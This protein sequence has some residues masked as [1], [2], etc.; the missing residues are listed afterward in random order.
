MGLSVTAKG[1][2][3]AEVSAHLAEVYGATVSK[4]KIS[5]DHRAVIEE[6]TDWRPVLDAVYP[7]VRPGQVANRAFY[8]TIGV[9]VDGERDILG[10]WSY[11]RARVP[12]SGSGCSPRSRTAASLMC[13]SSSATASKGRPDSIPTTWPKAIVHTC[14]LHLLRNTFRLASRAVHS[15]S[16][17]TSAALLHRRAPDSMLLAANLAASWS[18]YTG[19]RTS[20][21]PSA[22]TITCQPFSVR[23]TETSKSATRFSCSTSPSFIG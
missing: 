2:T 8:V 18:A 5:P 16:G 17:S 19:S 1:L 14:V 20:C 12:S 15:G 4:E 10:I 7:V 21:T 6:I 22:V 13:A 23:W 11:F 9:A 3:T